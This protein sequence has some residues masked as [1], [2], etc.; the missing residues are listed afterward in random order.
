MIH[1]VGI[2]DHF[3]TDN[4]EDVLITYSLGSCIG[5]TVYDPIAHVGGMIHCMLPLSK[6]YPDKSSQNPFM[7]IDTGLTKLLQEVYDRGAKSDRLIIKIAGGAS[8]LDKTRM[9][10]I[11]ERNY[12]VTRKI[13]WKNNLLISSEEVGGS[14]S[15]T[16]MLYMGTGKTTIK[17]KG[18]EV[19]L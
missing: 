8:L 1:T 4:Q 2:S 19:E 14:K 12:A 13:L 5:V 3:V 10:R 15:R 11:G 7:F 18:L 6:M 9:F 17:N 16:L